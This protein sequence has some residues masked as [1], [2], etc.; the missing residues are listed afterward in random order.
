MVCMKNKLQNPATDNQGVGITKEQNRWEDVYSFGRERLPW[1]E[2]PL[3]TEILQDFINHLQSDHK[4][5]DYGCGD[6]LLTDF[7]IQGGFKNILCSDISRKA[8]DMVLQRH[9]AVKVV[10]A[11]EPSEIIEKPFDGILVWG[12]MH[13]VDYDQWEKFVYDFSNLVKPGGF[14]LFGGHS[15]K[16]VEFS[17]GY[18]VSPTTGEVST[19][20]DYLEEILPNNNLHIL[21]SGYFDFIESFSSCPRAFKYFL[22]QRI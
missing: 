15:R 18:R 22:S 13:H 8:L 10:R 6:G 16:D 20:V 12:V 1:L 19:A 9:S 11:N 4:I 2:N 5:L 17:Q 3:P 7:L 14:I 21:K